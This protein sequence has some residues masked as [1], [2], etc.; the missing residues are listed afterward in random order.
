MQQRDLKYKYRFHETP[1]VTRRRTSSKSIRYT[2]MTDKYISN[3]YNLDHIMLKCT[4]T[5][6]ATSAYDSE[7]IVYD[8]T[9]QREHNNIT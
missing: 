3:Q 7:S 5:D 1:R 4:C 2:L 6:P 9:S 8:D